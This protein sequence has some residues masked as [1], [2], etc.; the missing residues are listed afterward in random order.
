MDLITAI[1]SFFAGA[2]VTAIHYRAQNAHV[3]IEY[4]IS[5]LRSI[6]RYGLEY[7]CRDYKSNDGRIE[8][9]LKTSDFAVSSLDE[10]NKRYL[11]GCFDQFD[12]RALSIFELA[13]GGDF[14]VKNRKADL[15]RAISLKKEISDC[16]LILRR[17]KFIENRLLA[18]VEN[19]AFNLS[20][21]FRRG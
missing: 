6:E 9:I 20:G 11:G 2:A 15:D 19:I 10:L 21:F 7:W 18:R 17:A 12:E 16:I 5:E 13:T 4:I 14:E 1:T 8:I 3:H